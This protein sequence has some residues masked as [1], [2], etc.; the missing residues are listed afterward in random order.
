MR[1]APT[2]MN[3][4]EREVTTAS[5]LFAAAADPTV[6]A[7]VVKTNLTGLPTIRLS[8]GQTLTGATSGVVLHFAAGQ[9]GVQLSTNNQ[10]EGL[11]LEADPDRCA[12]YNDTKVEHLGRLILLKLRMIGTIR[13]LASGNVRS[14]HIEAENIEI[15]SADARGYT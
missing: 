7:I 15:A 14:G 4:Q 10:L 5:E 12:L 8:P 6:A 1:K 13:L 3:H 11:A 9:D 2:A